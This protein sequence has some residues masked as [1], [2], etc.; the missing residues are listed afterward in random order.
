[1][2]IDGGIV[3]DLSVTSEQKLTGLFQDVV[4]VRLKSVHDIDITL[5]QMI[6]KK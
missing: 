6:K 1:M 3:D 4:K 2:E 5:V